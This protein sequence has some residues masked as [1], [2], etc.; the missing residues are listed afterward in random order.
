VDIVEGSFL[1]Q[2]GVTTS[3]THAVDTSN[4]RASA[5]ILRNNASGSTGSGELL[6][7]RL[8]A[9]SVGPFELTIASIRA[10]S[11]GGQVSVDP[12][13]VLKLTAK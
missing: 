11:L 8:R 13:P 6:Q 5:G 3:F 1:R 4:G 2:G 9:K 10:I 7:L 12:L